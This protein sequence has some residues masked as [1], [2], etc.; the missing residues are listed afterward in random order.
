MGQFLSA[1]HNNNPNNY[2]IASSPS[3]PNHQSLSH[4][5][6]NNNHSH[7]HS[8]AGNNNFNHLHPNKAFPPSSPIPTHSPKSQ[9]PFHHPFASSN[10]TLNSQQ[11]QTQFGHQYGS[12]ANVAG[13]TGKS[14]SMW[15]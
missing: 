9:F 11:Q 12:S 5:N 14:L 6:N 15:V 7:H 8:V 3:S 13:T 1:N 10:A 2:N 4:N